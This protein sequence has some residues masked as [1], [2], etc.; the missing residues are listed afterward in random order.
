[1]AGYRF[2]PVNQAGNSAGLDPQKLGKT[3]VV[4]S[5]GKTF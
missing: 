2:E 5:V 4:L 3:A 1:M